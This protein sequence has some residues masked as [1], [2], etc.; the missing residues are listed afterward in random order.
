MIDTE[1]RIANPEIVRIP[2]QRRVQIPQLP[3][4][5]GILYA[6][7]VWVDVEN[8]EVQ[9]RKVFGSR[10]PRTFFATF[11]PVLLSLSRDPFYWVEETSTG[12][13]FLKIASTEE[14]FNETPKSSSIFVPEGWFERVSC[15]ISNGITGFNRSGQAIL[16]N[17]EV[18]RVSFPRKSS[19]PIR[20][21]KHPFYDPQLN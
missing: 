8:L 20:F 18:G 15:L 9:T 5:G 3:F 16:S 10:K 11:S 7:I 13:V 4:F 12:E 6:Y 14:C 19:R 17:G 1:V 21:A 2:R